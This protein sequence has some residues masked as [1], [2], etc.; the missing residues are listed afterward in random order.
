[1][2]NKIV[3][4]GRLTRDPELRRT[5]AGTAVCSF[6]IACDRNY[7]KDEEKKTDFL[8][9]VA[10]RERG[11]FVAKY[12]AKGRMIVVAG[13]LQNRDW[14]DKNGNKRRSAEINADNVYFG[15]SKP[16]QD[17]EEDAPAY[18]SYAA[19]DGA[20]FAEEEGGFGGFD[21]PDGFNPGFGG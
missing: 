14:T 16:K 8:D 17:G 10:W 3:V 12:F 20:G 13:S 15:D 2:L 1:M 21:V 4:M 5:Q 19:S 9:I 18:G 6:S 7:G 11:E